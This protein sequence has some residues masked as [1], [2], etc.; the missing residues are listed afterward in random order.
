M[1][2]TPRLLNIIFDEIADNLCGGLPVYRRLIVQL[3]AF[4]SFESE[5]DLDIIIK[6]LT[7]FG[8]V[9]IVYSDF[10]LKFDVP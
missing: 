9:N 4:I 7:A 3:D 5:F 6:V 1:S 2:Q 8:C 10:N